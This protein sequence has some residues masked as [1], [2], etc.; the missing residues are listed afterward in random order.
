MPR[1]KPG[2]PYGCGKS[3]LKAAW[4]PRQEQKRAAHID[5]GKKDMALLTTE[6]LA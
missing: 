2:S 4:W 5:G 6:W 1:A 3:T